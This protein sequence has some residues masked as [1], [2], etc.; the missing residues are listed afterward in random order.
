MPS[1]TK[2]PSR[3][4][5]A[6]NS[7]RLV[8]TLDSLGCPDEHYTYE[9]GAVYCYEMADENLFRSL[10]RRKITHVAHPEGVWG[11]PAGTHS[12]A[13]CAASWREHTR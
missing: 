6:E 8:A 5:K 9:E 12:V 2:K 4:R 3:P 1:K 7:A 10:R 11:L 13:E